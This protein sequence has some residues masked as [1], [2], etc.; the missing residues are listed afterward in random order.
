LVGSV[1]DGRYRIVEMIA[2]G[3]MAYVYR[4][5]QSADPPEVALK[6]LSPH[7]ARHK[8]AAARFH[9]EANAVSKL[10]HPGV[11]KIYGW[12][13]D[14]EMPFIAMELLAGDDLF[15]VLAR[16]GRVPQERAARLMTSVC[17]GLEAAHEAGVV[18]RDLKPE[19]I[20]VLPLRPDGS[21]PIKL[22][23][24]G[25]AKLLVGERG[26][27][28]WSEATVP[29]VLTKVGSAVGTP[30]HMAPEQARGIDVDSRADVYACGV[31]LY[32]MVTGHLPFEGDNPVQVA[33]RQVSDP[34]LPPS[35]HL[36]AIHPQFEVIILRCLEKDREA[37]F[38]SA[39]EL[40]AALVD[41]LKILALEDDSTTKDVTLPT[42]PRMGDEETI[43]HKR[44][45][46]AALAVP[47]A[48]GR[49]GT[50]LMPDALP[51]EE[52]LEG[53]TAQRK[54]PSPIADPDSEIELPTVQEGFDQVRLRREIEIAR[55]RAREAG[56]LMEEEVTADTAPGRIDGARAP[57]SEAIPST[58]P[59]PEFVPNAASE[60]APESA[61]DSAPESAPDSAPDSDPSL[62]TE[63]LP[64]G[65]DPLV[66]ARLEAS[67]RRSA[68]DSD[69]IVVRPKPSESGAR[70]R[71]PR[72]ELESIL[73][74][75]PAPARR[76]IG[77]FI[78]AFVATL[79]AVAA[80]WVVIRGMPTPQELERLRFW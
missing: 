1:I 16:Q 5:T 31:V 14:G 4:A 45:K 7:I 35:R 36:P 54:K 24:F 50:E 49:R 18:H 41:L 23:D 56:T 68:G 51:L 46:G 12:G 76:R 20:Q 43:T 42:V 66:E 19:N 65:L 25:I 28:S 79:L 3:A 39:A 2:T 58:Q 67:S 60:S 40:Q 32:E 9:R 17:Q 77:P 48:R 61:P 27:D 74:K 62:A 73:N 10:R 78:L 8:T 80:L 22:L 53:P 21:E 75:M 70:K 11:V 15:A 47:P 37:R 59:V 13:V 44:A 34:P 38:Q 57:V 71:P 26:G 55:R 33:V 72:R 30:S 29:Q 52:A 64:Q 6:V 63:V 69:E